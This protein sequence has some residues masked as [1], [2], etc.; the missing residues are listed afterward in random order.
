MSAEPYDLHRAVS[1]VP[2][3]HRLL[4]QAPDAERGVLCSF[5]IAP[6]EIGAMCAELKIGT[7]HFHLPAYQTI[8]STLLS[9]WSQERPIDFITL[10]QILRD[11]GELDQVGGPGLITELF[12]F[13]PTA[14]NA[15]QYL[16]ILQEKLYLRDI[17]K[18]CTE[19]AAR[20][21]DE[22]DQVPGIM[23]EVQEKIAGLG[24]S[25][26]V[27]IPT[28]R[29]NIADAL[30]GLE[31]RLDNGANVI[32]TGLAS[33]D[34]DCGP[35]E[36]SNL[37]VIGGQTKAGKSILA[38]Q[39]A[40]NVAM[41]GKP[42]LFISLEMTERELTLRFLGIL[43]RV[44]TRQVRTWTEDEHA[45]FAAAQTTLLTANLTIVT[46]L[47]AL[48]EIVA[49]CQRVASRP[50]EPLAAIVLDY[51][52]LTEGMRQKKDDRRQQEIAE[53]S[54]TCKRLAGR[55]NVLFLLLT[56]LN[57][58]G[59]TREGRDI[60]NDANL[61]VE[62]GHNRETGERGVKVVLA[63]SAP[64]GQRL[65]LRIIPEHT[66]VEDAPEMDVEPRDD[67]RPKRRKDR[68]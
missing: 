8:Y 6:R 22:Q 1:Y 15:G 11:R 30:L 32:R 28:M 43:A 67:P 50:G 47:Y 44:D 55:H 10:T 19:Y 57:D 39:I 62:V 23:A 51:A 26:A 54:R 48:S 20:S 53:I 41:S 5:L 14:A 61:M 60:E 46:R 36:R 24:M 40:L 2:D 34:E 21:Y 66:R 31:G 65:K 35:L 33:L 58:D 7:G 29:E 56:Q 18:I 64:S 59:R 9:F 16:E 37:F 52:Q 4:P 13:L 45:R 42:V 38:G 25:R 3:I 17:I 27:R 63:R 12:T 49:C 68:H